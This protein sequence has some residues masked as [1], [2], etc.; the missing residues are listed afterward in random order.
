MHQL[1]DP[2]PTVPAEAYQIENPVQRIRFVRDADGDLWIEVPGMPGQFALAD[3][4]K[5][6]KKYPPRYTI[7][8][9]D[10]ETDRPLTIEWDSAAP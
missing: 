4:F 9:E 3:D 5:R 10:L 1:S 2:D 8:I 6:G 7:T